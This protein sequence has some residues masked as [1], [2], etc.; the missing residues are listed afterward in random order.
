MILALQH[1]HIISAEPHMSGVL[2]YP[3]LPFQD[4]RHLSET[5]DLLLIRQ[6]RFLFNF[7]HFTR[8]TFD[9]TRLK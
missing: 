5:Y 3:R 7:P 8:F 6:S 9:K 2:V 4:M 1:T